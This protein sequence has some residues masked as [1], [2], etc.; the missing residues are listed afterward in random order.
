MNITVMDQIIDSV[1][2][3]QGGYRRGNKAM[4]ILCYG[5]DAK[6]KAERAIYID[7]YINFN[8]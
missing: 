5:D 2:T 6:L 8:Q 7:N 3:L 4:K 1:K